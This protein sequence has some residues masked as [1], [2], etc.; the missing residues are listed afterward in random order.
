GVNL[1]FGEDGE[2]KPLGL[3]FV[4]ALLQDVLPKTMPIFTVRDPVPPLSGDPKV[5]FASPSRGSAAV[6]I[7]NGYIEFR[8]PAASA[9]STLATIPVLEALERAKVRLMQQP[10]YYGNPANASEILGSH[11]T[12]T[13]ISDAMQAA[14]AEAFSSDPEAAEM[15]GKDLRDAVAQARSSLASERA[16]AAGR[17]PSWVEKES[18]RRRAA[19]DNGKDQALGA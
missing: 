15:L 17:D 4:D 10:D 16:N 11:S 6:R 12:G 5:L 19:Q 2:L 1:L 18:Q 13:V 3:A 7:R 9:D 14:A 8:L